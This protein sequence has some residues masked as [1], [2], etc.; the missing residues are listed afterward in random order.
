M[1]VRLGVTRTEVRGTTLPELA[2]A[3]GDLLLRGRGH[4]AGIGDC[5]AAHRQRE[6]QT[7]QLA[8][9]SSSVEETRRPSGEAL[10]FGLCGLSLLAGL[11]LHRGRGHALRTLLGAGPGVENGLV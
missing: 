4:H 11:R 6:G 8:H 9:L 5:A 10:R 1:H 2:E 3:A 7:E